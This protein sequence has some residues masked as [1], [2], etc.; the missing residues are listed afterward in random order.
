MTG[1]LIRLDLA[2]L[3]RS[4]AF[5]LL[6]VLLAAAATLALVSGLDW[7]ARYTGAAEAAREKV[8]A[9]R[10][11]LV[12][13][14]DAL[15]A[16]TGEPTDVD[17]YDG[18]GAFIP[19]PRDP[20]VAGFYHS[21]LA[22]LPAGPLLGLATG[23]S[24]LR[25]THHLLKTVPIASL[26]RIG[27]PAERVNPGALAAGRF[28]LLAFIMFLCPL[29]L[30]ALL[31]DASAREREAGL[32]PLLAGLGASQRELLLARGITR[33]GAVLAAALVASIAGI[34]LV[35]ALGTMAAAAWLVGVTAYI[36]F[37]TA[38]LL[39]VASS[40]LSVIGS[41]AISVSLWVALLLLSPGV[42]ER[43]L[44]P[45][46]LL[47]PRALAEAEVRAVI[48][49]ATA[50]DRARAAAKQT[51]AA[52]YWNIDFASAPACA[53]REG[54]LSEYVERR[55]SDETYKAAMLQG[56]AREAVYDARLDQW[57]WLSPPLAFRRAMETVAGADPARQRAF[58][59][60]VFAF[61]AAR[62]DRVT[63]ALFACRSFDR[64]AFDAAPTFAYREPARGASGWLGIV[65]AGVLAVALGVLAL[66]RRALFA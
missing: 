29:A 50:D 43:I 56:A 12:D 14:Y 19:D 39:F 60:Q 34:A 46:G 45:S 21:Q 40:G 48:R 57:S 58:E 47:E 35:G 33:G 53:N 18:N 3:R 38:L 1:A 54:V 61:H 16:G 63:D 25:A 28:D 9:D 65:L 8:A 23:T 31:F 37:W 41:A 5:W 6:M 27:E 51:V 52:Q 7:R 20:Y 55:L 22:E 17:A 32:A 62:R 10:Q 30:A 26:M 49:E 24:E 66:R 44:R 13:V 59:E 15:A 4:R 42:V 36:V 64:A 11:V 2:L